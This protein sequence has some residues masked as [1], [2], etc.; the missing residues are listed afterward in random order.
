M[1]DSENQTVFVIDPIATPCADL[2]EWGRGG[3]V[4]EGGRTSLGKVKFLKFT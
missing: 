3:G 2:E 1:E 4:D